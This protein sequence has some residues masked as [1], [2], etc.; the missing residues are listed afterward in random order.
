MIERVKNFRHLEQYPKLVAEAVPNERCLPCMLC[1]PV[2]PSKAIKVIFNKTREDFGPLRK[3]IKGKISID[4]EKCNFCGRC[5]KFC[6]AFVLIDKIDKDPRDLVPYEQILIDEE[7]CDYCGLCV[8]LCPEEAI[9]V[10]GEP[11][12]DED[13]KFE[14]VIEVDKE[15][16]IGCGRCAIVCPYEAI[17]LKKPFDGDIELIDKYLDKCDPLGC[18]ACFNVCPAKCWYVDDRGKAAPVKEQCILCGACAIVC[19]VSAIR[20][21]RSNV[22][23]TDIKDVPWAF[24][25]KDAISSIVTGEKRRPDVSGALVPPFRE[26]LPQPKIEMIKRDPELLKLIDEVLSP[27]ETIFKKPKVR[28]ILE[29]EP[30]EEASAKILQR[31]KIDETSKTEI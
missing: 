23:H 21:K 19:P 27:L 30:P 18:Q 22:H 17:D 9:E 8:S 7:L 26:K 6:K 4:K 5:P 11:I 13:F 24:E 16:C 2:C 29:K 31:L 20:V 3:N 15:L 12:I 25:W 28:Q 10:E 1:E 14:S